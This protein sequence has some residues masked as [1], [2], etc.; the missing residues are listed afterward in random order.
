[1]AKRYKDGESQDDMKVNLRVRTHIE[2]HE[3]D[4]VLWFVV[5][6]FLFHGTGPHFAG[7]RPTLRRCGKQNHGLQG[8][9]R[10]LCKGKRLE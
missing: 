4:Y 8:L 1:V 7:Y 6:L 10:L 2:Q 3:S 9:L 5:S